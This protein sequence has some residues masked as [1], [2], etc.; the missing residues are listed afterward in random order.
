[1]PGGVR[2]IV[3]GLDVSFTTGVAVVDTELRELVL[4][5]RVVA[6]RTGVSL[7]A[8]RSRIR[9]C[10]DGVLRFIPE[11]VDLIVLEQPLPPVKDR[12]GLQIERGGA[13]FMLVDQ[14][15]HRAPL[16]E[17]NPRTRAKFATGSGNASKD[18]VVTAMRAAFPHVRIQDDNVADAVALAVAGARWLGA[19]LM[20]FSAKQ[21]EAYGAVPWPLTEGI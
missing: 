2:V 4:A 3:V 20:E 8:R 17:V 11:H 15:A 16:V 14:L 13:Y 19:P 9:K 10:V 12:A 18:D 5:T 1:M 7:M 21:D 6:P